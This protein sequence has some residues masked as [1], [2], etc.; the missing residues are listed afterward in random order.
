M[1]RDMFE[2]PLSRKNNKIEEDIF[3]DRYSWK[4]TY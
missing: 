2:T 3:Q 1:L 4:M